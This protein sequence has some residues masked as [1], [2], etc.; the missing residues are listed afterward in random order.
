MKVLFYVMS[1]SFLFASVS[2]GLAVDKDLVAYYSFNG[3]TNDT[4][5]N[6]NNG[7]IVGRSNWDAGKF[8]KAIHLNAGEHVQIQASNTLHKDLFKTDPYTISV[9]I[10]PTF[11]GGDWQHIWR[12]LPEASG[13]NTLFL[14]KNDALLSWRGRTSAGWTTLCQTDAGV[15]EM[16]VWAH[17]IVQSDGSTFRIYIDGEMAKEADFQETVGGIDTY[18]FG[19]DGTEGYGGAIDDAA[20][21]SRALD[22][23]DIKALGKGFDEAFPI[24]PKDKL[25]TSWGNIKNAI[26]Y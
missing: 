4:S 17:V 19:G 11:E 7:D 1:I 13:H 9:W 22:E 21:Y 18:R 16:G 12:S 24:Q 14:N 15:I 8:G 6:K 20:I 26:Y 2:L 25:T 10:N 3:N 23:K 5:G